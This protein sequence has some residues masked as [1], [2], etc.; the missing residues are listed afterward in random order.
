MSLQ[1]L[2]TVLTDMISEKNEALAHQ[3]LAAQVLADKLERLQS[4]RDSSSPPSTRGTT[5]EVGVQSP[6]LPRPPRP[7]PADSYF[8]DEVFD[9]LPSDHDAQSSRSMDPS[10]SEGPV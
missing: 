8:Y 9:L 6:S 7:T 10:H 4:K 2:V 5:R 1:E 3:K